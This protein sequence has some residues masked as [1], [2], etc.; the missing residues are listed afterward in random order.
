MKTNL[1]TIYKEAVKLSLK[2]QLE[3]ISRLAFSLKQSQT[4]KGHKL[5][6]LE[7]LGKEIWQKIDVEKYVQ[8]LRGEWSD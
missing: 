6:E 5:F 2:D 4:I 8:N 3:L 1:Y 7:G